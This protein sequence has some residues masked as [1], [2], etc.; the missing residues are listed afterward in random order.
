[1]SPVET[2]LAVLGVP[3]FTALAILLI[4]YLRY[5]VS[6]Q[7]VWRDRVLGGLIVARQR[8]VAERNELESLTEKREDE[9]KA[10]AGTTPPPD[11]AARLEALWPKYEELEW[12]ARAR[13]KAAQVVFQ[14]LQSNAAL[15]GRVTFFRYLTKGPAALVPSELLRA[16][17]PDAA[18]IIQAA[19]DRARTA[20]EQRSPQE[21]E[22][23]P[24]PPV[25]R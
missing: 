14:K 20:H 7:K 10:L 12:R 6:A 22:L 15:A 4:L 2:L 3:V 24:A 23:P 11:L 1:M 8:M 9:A 21:L 5:S 25:L 16:A 18:A 19:D 13:M 17:L